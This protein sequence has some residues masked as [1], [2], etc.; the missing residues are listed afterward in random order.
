MRLGISHILNHKT[1]EEWAEKTRALGLGAVVFPCSD[2]AGEEKIE[3]YRAACEKYDLT[4]AEVGVWKNTMSADKDESAK[5]IEKCKSLLRMA[6]KIGARCCV[7]ISG[8]SGMVWD[9]GYRENY[10]DE[11]Y[12]RLVDQVRGIIDSVKPEKACYA[13]EPMPWMLPYS[14][15]SY[16]SLIR[17]VDREKF[18]VHMDAVNMINCPERYF[19]SGKFIENCFHLLGDRILSCHVKD[20]MLQRTLTL[21]LKEVPCGQGEFNIDKYALLADRQDSDM[22]FIIEHLPNE[23]AYLESVGYLKGVCSRLGI[24]L[25]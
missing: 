20:V 22:P 4:I 24:R 2:D 9:G 21:H 11:T 3:A 6:D 5:N 8:T 13:L 10:S 1:P 19:F 7:N 18:G 14:P 15:Q 17:A 16:I 12:E 25:K 23:A